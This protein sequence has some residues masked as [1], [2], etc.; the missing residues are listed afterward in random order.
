MVK[1]QSLLWV[2]EIF[3]ISLIPIFTLFFVYFENSDIYKSLTKFDY[4]EKIILYRFS[5]N[6]ERIENSTEVKNILNKQLEP[7][8]FRVV[9]DFI[10]DHAVKLPSYEPQM[11]SIL[12]PKNL[13]YVDYPSGRFYLIPDSVPISVSACYEYQ[14]VDGTCKGP[15][16]DTIVGTLED[17]KNWYDDEKR[18]IRDFINVALGSIAIVIAMILWN[19]ERKKS[20][21][22]LNG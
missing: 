6:T 21:L 16:V 18:Q 9:W 19:I 3:V 4:L 22:L 12:G 17:F 1:T 14:L 15:E 11:I 13:P 20:F 8:E 2:A 5:M 7:E 10:K